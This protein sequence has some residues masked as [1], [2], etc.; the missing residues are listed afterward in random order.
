M[1]ELVTSLLDSGL[2]SAY[3][4]VQGKIQTTGCGRIKTELMSMIASMKKTISP[5]NAV[6]RK[7]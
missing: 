7:V 5:S 6:K 4:A 1:D 2:H 3:S